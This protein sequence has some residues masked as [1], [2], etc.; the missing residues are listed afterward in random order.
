MRLIIIKLIHT[1]IW[2][3]MASCVLFVLV[4]GIKG[5]L[6]HYVYFAILVIFL[7]GVI[8]LIFKWRCPLTII[9]QRYTDRQ[10]DTFDIFLPRLLA[11]YNKTIFTTLFVIG[12]ALITLRYINQ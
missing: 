3:F 9:A 7:E 8:L 11:K 10:D 2:F 1:A 6:N 12:L 4:A 5:F